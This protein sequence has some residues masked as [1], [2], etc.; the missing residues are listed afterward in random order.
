MEFAS[1]HRLNVK[2]WIDDILPLVEDSTDPLGVFDLTTHRL[3]LGDAAQ[4]L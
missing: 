2:T 1:H 4:G 3:P